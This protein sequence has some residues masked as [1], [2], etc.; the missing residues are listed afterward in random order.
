MFDYII[1]NMIRNKVLEYRVE[2]V[3]IY[4]TKMDNNKMYIYIGHYNTFTGRKALI[5]FLMLYVHI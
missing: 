3:D 2:E 1:I 5:K 4:F